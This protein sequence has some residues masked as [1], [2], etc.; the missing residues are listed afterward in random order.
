MK[1]HTKT[2]AMVATIAHYAK[3]DPAKPIVIYVSNDR[4]RDAVKQLLDAELPGWSLLPI[5]FLTYT[6]GDLVA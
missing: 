6:P 5:R 2:A 4:D 3:F 1:F